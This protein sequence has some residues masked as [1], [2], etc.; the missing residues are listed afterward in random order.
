MTL[1]KPELAFS[2]IESSLRDELLSEYEG[3]Q[4]AFFS[5]RW[6][7]CGLAAGRF[8][9]V[10]FTIISDLAEGTASKTASKPK[11]F[12]GS[13]RKL[14]S[15][16]RLVD[17]IRFHAVKL[18]PVLYD[19]RNKRDIGH[20]NGEISPSQMD[21]NLCVMSSSWILAELIRVMH[22][23]PLPAAQQVVSS[24]VEIKSPVVWEGG[25]IRR[26]AVTGLSR[27]D[28]AILL[29]AS[30]QGKTSE[31]D[32]MSWMGISQRSNLRKIL[33]SLHQDRYIEAEID[34]S[35]LR[36]MPKGSER[37][38]NILQGTANH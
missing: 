35:N 22:N 13:C 18:L 23:M 26:L 4:S 38:R 34:R 9:E 24:I 31:D 30:N 1:L 12:A 36:I 7:D 15:D 14:E 11:D 16:T 3:M 10:V 6:R 25:D 28:E 21:A 37:S 17:G 29:I 8:C 5:S 33:K 32:L 20:V 19:I 27:A 2:G